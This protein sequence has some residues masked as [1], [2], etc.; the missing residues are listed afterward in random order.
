MHYADRHLAA[1]RDTEAAY[2]RYLGSMSEFA[3]RLVQHG[4][5]LRILQGDARHDAAVRSDL[6]AELTRRGLNYESHHVADDPSMSVGEL[7]RQIAE[8]DIVIS[9]RFHNLILALL[10]GIP[11]I[12][13]SYD[14]KS[15]HLLDAFGLGQFCHSIAAIDVDRLIGQL[16][17][18]LQ[19]RHERGPLLRLKSEALRAVLDEQFDLILT[20]RSAQQRPEC[21]PATTRPPR[22]GTER[23]LSRYGAPTAAPRLS[24]R[25]GTSQ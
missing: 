20:Q 7:T 6:R 1:A 12:S 25:Q 8:T 23:R 11:V 15:D 19:L 10:M 16:R 4:Y 2:R 24:G 22:S 9:P 5:G 14:P 21:P 13:I 17:E 3:I 18:L